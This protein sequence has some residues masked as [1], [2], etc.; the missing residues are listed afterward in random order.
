V[1]CGVVCA[2]CMS[3]CTPQ[4]HSPGGNCGTPQELLGEKSEFC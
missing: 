2:L 3:P 1:W 4:L